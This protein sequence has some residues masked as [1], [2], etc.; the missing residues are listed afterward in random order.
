MQA[1]VSCTGLACGVLL[2]AVGLA[3]WGG[4]RQVTGLS[5]VVQAISW[6]ASGLLALG[7]LLAWRAGAA[8]AVPALR[9]II[10]A[11][12]AAAAQRARRRSDSFWSR[13]LPILPA[14]VLATASLLWMLRSAATGAG[15]FPIT[16]AELAVLICAGFGAQT[17]GEALGEVADP[18]LR[19]ERPALGNAQE[20]SAVTYALLTLAVAGIALANLGQR[21]V[22]W[23]GTASEEGLAGV[24]LV[25][26]AAWVSPRQRRWLRSGLVVAA[27]L[28]LIL[29]ALKQA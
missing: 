4:Y 28:L 25:W 26:S 27:A 13:V 29:V 8:I 17:L 14:L 11:A 9:L 2:A 21:G 16:L 1:V 18:A 3:L 6:L 5:C 22:A 12:V 10:L 20:S 15:G 24:W 7:A 19:I 23:R